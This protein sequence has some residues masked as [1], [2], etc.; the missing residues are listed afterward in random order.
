M[1]IFKSNVL[2]L[3]NGLIDFQKLVDRNKVWGRLKKLSTLKK[4]SFQEQETILTAKIVFTFLMNMPI[5]I[6][7]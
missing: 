5:G 2:Q 7:P 6:P 4:L 1:Q 3:T